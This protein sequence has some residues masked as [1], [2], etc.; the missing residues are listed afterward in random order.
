MIANPEYIHMLQN[1]EINS[2]LIEMI[3]EFLV[4]CWEDYNKPNM[5]KK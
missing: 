4:L 3:S 2:K 5:K 1:Y